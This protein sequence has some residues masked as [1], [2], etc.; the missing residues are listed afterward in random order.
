MTYNLLVGGSIGMQQI[1]FAIL[2]AIQNIHTDFL[3][4]FILAI[5]N[6]TGSYG[7]LWVILAVLLLFFKKTRKAGFTILISYAMVFVVGQYGLKDLIA[8]PR[9]CHMDETVALLVSRPSSFSCPSTHSAWA[10][11]AAASVFSW[12][13]KFGIVVGVIA[14]IVAFGRLYLF[15]HFPT[16]VLFGIALGILF[17]FVAYSIVKAADRKI[18]DK[19]KAK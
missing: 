13:K 6:I 8:R 12:H 18:K 10:F 5:M 19:A 16:D 3:D 7:Q 15:V 11:A 2:Y 14:L 4:R 17:A 1:E 9:P